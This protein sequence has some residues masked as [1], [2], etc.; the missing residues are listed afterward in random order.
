MDQEMVKS[1]VHR[2]WVMSVLGTWKALI[3]WLRQ[4]EIENGVV[5]LQ[6]CCGSVIACVFKYIRVEI[7]L[8]SP[9]ELLSVR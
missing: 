7:V 4:R 2:A 6:A 8:I 1:M 3:V 5:S 9:A